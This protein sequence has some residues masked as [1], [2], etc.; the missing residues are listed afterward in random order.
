MG[1]P[2]GK[3]KT[4]YSVEFKRD[5]VRRME[6]CT[7]IAGLARELGVRRKFLYKWREQL[8]KHGEAG[9]VP[10]QG[11]PLDRPR[12]A[13]RAK[14][15]PAP[16]RAQASQEAAAWGKR[17]AELE[18]QLG[19]K[20]LE[21]DFFKH[22]FAHVREAMGDRSGDGAPEFTAA[23]KHRFRAKGKD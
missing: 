22:T 11:R 1:R 4:G 2:I 6:G 21:V 14:V 7:N 18:R 10:H 16:Q 3:K 12:S 19:Q 5:A 13:S 9:L 20:Q 23:S 15:G 8:L 17:V